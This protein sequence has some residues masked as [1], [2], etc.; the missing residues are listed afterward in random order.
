MKEIQ[1]QENEGIL[2]PQF[3]FSKEKEYEGK[4]LG[5]Y[6]RMAQK[7]L[8]ENYKHRYNS[9]LM[10]GKLLPMMHQVE[11]EAKEQLAIIIEKLLTQDP[12]KNP[13]N[14]LE[15]VQHRNQIKAQAEE[16]ILQEII[17]KKR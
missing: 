16:I 6:G 10:E 12:I 2:Y 7:F 9:L 8:K 14:F 15:T 13:Q 4:Q 1:Y 3:N 17:Y 5:K 11:K